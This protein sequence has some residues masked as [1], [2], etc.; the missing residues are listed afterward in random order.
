MTYQTMISSCRSATSLPRSDHRLHIS[1]LVAYVFAFIFCFELSMSFCAESSKFFS[2]AWYVITCKN[3]SHQICS[4]FRFM[5]KWRWWTPDD[6]V[7]VMKCGCPCWDKASGLAAID[8]LLTLC[9]LLCI[10]RISSARRCGYTYVALSQLITLV[11]KFTCTNS[12]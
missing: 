1:H 4:I 5:R 9:L 2:S 11:L 3:V 10:S 12:C 7:I 8:M 6:E